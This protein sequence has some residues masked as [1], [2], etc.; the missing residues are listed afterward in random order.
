MSKQPYSIVFAV[1]IAALSVCAFSSCT[2]YEKV[3]KK[4]QPVFDTSKATAV[5]KDKGIYSLKNINFYYDADNDMVVRIPDNFTYDITADNKTFKS[6]NEAITISVD[7]KNIDIPN[8]SNARDFI[9]QQFE[10]TPSDNNLRLKELNDSVVSGTGTYQGSNFYE[11]WA[12]TTDNGK[13]KIKTLRYEYLPLPQIEQSA[14][15]FFPTTVTPFPSKVV[16]D[17]VTVEEDWI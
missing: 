15:A 10:K 17:N 5:D 13:A 1:L 2:K 7:A 14:E 6:P 12:Y 11:K 16:T 4:D 3:E 8:G 9:R